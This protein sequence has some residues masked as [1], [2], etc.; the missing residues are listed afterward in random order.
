MTFK[1][2]CYKGEQMA[3]RIQRRKRNRIIEARVGW[4]RERQRR[5]RRRR[6]NNRVEKLFFPKETAVELRTDQRFAEALG[7]KP[8]E[9]LTTSLGSR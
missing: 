6:C 5:L 4:R 1:Y 3:V 9:Q 8:R 2:R 7:G